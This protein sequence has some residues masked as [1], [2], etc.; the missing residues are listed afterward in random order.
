MRINQETENYIRACA[1]TL[2]VKE[3]CRPSPGIKSSE[4]ILTPVDSSVPMLEELRLWLQK[5]ACT[6]GN[7]NRLSRF[8][9]NNPDLC[10]T[11]GV[12]KIF[13]EYFYTHV[14][15]VKRLWHR[16]SLF[17]CSLSKPPCGKPDSDKQ[18]PLCHQALWTELQWA[19]TLLPPGVVSRTSVSA[20]PFACA[21]SH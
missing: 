6:P 8:I 13:D 18:K 11:K 1:I 12:Q 7:L 9:R 15:E 3:I 14:N 4:I 5:I 19:R 2:K 10:K 16:Q 17:Y 21:A 20:N